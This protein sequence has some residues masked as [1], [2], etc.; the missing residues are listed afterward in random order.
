L[1]QERAQRVDH[2]ITGLWRGWLAAAAHIKPVVGENRSQLGERVKD[3]VPSLDRAAGSMTSTMMGK[4]LPAVTYSKVS[5]LSVARNF[6][7]MDFM[8]A[9]NA[10]VFASSSRR[11]PQ[12][13]QNQRRGMYVYECAFA[14]SHQQM[15]LQNPHGC[16]LL[17]HAALSGRLG[18]LR[19]VV[20]F[21]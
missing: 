8:P 3:F 2:Y 10:R 14:L 1:T 4:L 5:L 17:K 13:P 7:G 11:I 18:G 20:H 21:V 9:A 16:C 6:G 19:G 12:E 15:M